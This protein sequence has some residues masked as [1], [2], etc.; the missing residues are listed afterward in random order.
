MKI[1]ICILRKI[2]F[3]SF[4][5]GASSEFRLERTKQNKTKLVMYSV[6]EYT[7]M[8]QNESNERNKFSKSRIIIFQMKYTTNLKKVKVFLTVHRIHNLFVHRKS[9]VHHQ[10][11]E[12]RWKIALINGR[13]TCLPIIVIHVYVHLNFTKQDVFLILFYD[14]SRTQKRC[15]ASNIQIC[16]LTKFK[17]GKVNKLLLH[18]KCNKVSY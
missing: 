3:R 9:P 15:S 10:S 8:K 5:F 17:V 18:Y 6:K 14:T 7:E 16:F 12:G 11:Q 13:N 4:G 2:L 1:V